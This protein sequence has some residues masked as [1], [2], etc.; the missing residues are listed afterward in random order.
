MSS[1]RVLSG[2]QPTGALHIGNW[3][4]AIRNWV[5]LQD[6]H[7]TYFCVV[8]LHAITTTHNPKQLAF[9][10]LSTYYSEKRGAIKN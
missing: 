2:V 7:E 8:D 1:K 9:N 10:S 5:D 3:L 6:N 4:G